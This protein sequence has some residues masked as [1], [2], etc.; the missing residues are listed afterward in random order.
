MEYLLL[1]GGLIL[2]VVS[3]NYL[4]ESAVDIAKKFKLS[5]LTIGMTIVA[6]GTSAPELMVSVQAAL[7]GFPEIALG[8]VVGSNI[9]NI[10]LIL[11]LTALILPIKT[12]RR[13]VKI[14]WPFLVLISI[15]LVVF[16]W[17]GSFDRIEG[18]VAVLLLILFTF[19]SIKSSRQSQEEEK[20]SSLPRRSIQLSVVIFI[21]ACIGLAY[22]A[23]FMVQGASAIATKLGISER[24]VSVL[25]VGVG[26]SLPELTAS[27]IAAIKK[28]DDMSLGNIIGSNIFNILAVLGI[29]SLIKPIAFSDT[30]FH[31]DFIWML[32]FA[33]F[34]YFGIINVNDNIRKF[35]DTK[36][37]KALF[38]TDNGLVGRI[39][40]GL[41]VTL[42]IIYAVL[43][44]VPKS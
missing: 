6:F 25:I 32:F 22:G 34:L 4:V 26:T 20:E 16:A 8:N 2:L 29:S 39:W 11:G 1:I 27:V 14:D 36:K 43:Q 41:A 18:A 10:G 21:I 5:S 30:G 7:N 23:D 12:S 38:S 42:Y 31:S 17:K 33:V 44:F 40:G 28:E 24:V 9:A 3:G 35:K 37:I 13:S 19:R 15:L